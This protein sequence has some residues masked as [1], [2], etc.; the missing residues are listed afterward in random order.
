MTWLI[1]PKF[2]GYYHVKANDM[3]QLKRDLKN[4][5]EF[6][7]TRLIEKLRD[8]ENP[9]E[10]YLL[11]FQN[12]HGNLTFINGPECQL[13]ALVSE[14]KGKVL[15]IVSAVGE[16]IPL[17]HVLVTDDKGKPLIGKLEYVGKKPKETIESFVDNFISTLPINVQELDYDSPKS[18]SLQKS[19]LCSKAWPPP[20][21]QDWPPVKRYIQFVA[22]EIPPKKGIKGDRSPKSSSLQISK[23][24]GTTWPLPKFQDC[25]PV[26]PPV[27]RSS[28]FVLPTQGIKGDITPTQN[29]Y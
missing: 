3:P 6:V 20:K 8:N 24:R 26:K 19:K 2:S 1:G 14:D 9:N 5:N 7:H 12:K 17:H 28:A 29:D 13:L 16:E 18:P 22:P 15:N 23:L 27:R 4:G 11:Y 25:S 10:K 21:F